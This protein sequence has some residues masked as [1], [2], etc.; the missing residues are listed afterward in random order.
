[1]CSQSPLLT[2]ALLS[3]SGQLYLWATFARTNFKSL[4]KKPFS[5]RGQLQSQNKANNLA[6]QKLYLSISG[7]LPLRLGGD[8]FY[9]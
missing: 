4:Q 1:M 2:E 5:F 9:I 3:V 8:L 7:D 6:T